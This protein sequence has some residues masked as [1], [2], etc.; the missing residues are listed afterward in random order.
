[1][2]HAEY[3]L[4]CSDPDA[5]ETMLRGILRTTRGADEDKQLG[6]ILLASFMLARVYAASD[7]ADEAVLLLDGFPARAA[8]LIPEHRDCA[9]MALGYINAILG[10]MNDIPQW[11]R[12][13]EIYDPPHCFL[14]QVF[15]FSFTVYAKSLMLQEKYQELSV[16]VSQLPASLVS[17]DNL[18]VRIHSAVALS[19]ASWH[20]KGRNAALARMREALE[21]CR[22]D[23]IVLPLAEYGRHIQPVL[24][25]LNKRAGSGKPHFET[26]FNWT[27]RM[28]QIT[29]YTVDGR[30]P[31]GLLT[32]R[33][34]EL[35]RY[36]AKGQSNRVIAEN[37]NVS[38]DAVKKVLSRAYVK[39][40]AT[41]RVDAVQ[42]F[43]EIY[44]NGD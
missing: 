20:T 22:P 32:Q 34:Q 33:E 14:P 44:G 23:G 43:S 12:E 7:R 11:L 17:M 8:N 24:R 39:L 28:A 1:M 37:N 26:V 36:A 35:L 6:V 16:A 40:E 42:R 31:K 18:Y 19:V 30:R 21:L 27:N 29:G 3:L 13:G 2:F 4:D 5:A 9:D 10:R 38:I 41:G 15:G 25:F